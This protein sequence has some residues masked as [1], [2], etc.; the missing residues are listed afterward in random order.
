MSIVDD[1]GDVGGN[2]CAGRILVCR[3]V[4]CAGTGMQGAC[5]HAYL[6]CAG[7]YGG[8]PA[9]VL[10][11]VRT[12]MCPCL[13]ARTHACAPHGWALTGCGRSACAA[14]LVRPR[15]RGDADGARGALLRGACVTR[16]LP[17]RPPQG[18]SDERVFVSARM[19]GCAQVFTPEH[20]RARVASRCESS[21][22]TATSCARCA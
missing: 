9:S 2:Q 10:A 14:R 20:A 21:A 22:D 1:N 17:A 16:P 13:R 11:D 5:M 8:C 6:V 4:D 7:M 3:G 18:L 12:G 15:E 19:R